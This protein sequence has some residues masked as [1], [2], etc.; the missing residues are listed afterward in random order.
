MQPVLPSRSVLFAAPARSTSRYPRLL[1]VLVMLCCGAC[2]RRSSEPDRRPAKSQS[3]TPSATAA[4]PAQ[5]PPAKPLAPPATPELPLQ[6]VACGEREFYRITQRSL[7]VFQVAEQQPPPQIRGNRIARQVAAIELTNPLNVVPFATKGALVVAETAVVRYQPGQ[8]Q[9]QRFAPIPVRGALSVL[10]DPRRAEA[11]RVRTLGEAKLEGY[12]LSSLPREPARGD[13]GPPPSLAKVTP[14]EVPLPDFDSRLFTLLADGAPLFST[15]KGLVRGVGD[16]S[17][18]ALPQLSAQPTL[19]FAD[20]SPQ[21]YWAADASGKLGLWDFKDAAA[22][23]LTSSVP[24]VVIDAAAEGD[25]VAV[26]SI[27]LTG[28]S[29]RPAVAIFA[30]GKEEARLSLGPNI[31][32]TSQPKLDLCLIAGRPWVVVGGRQW[33]QLF[34]WST[35]RLL[36]E[37]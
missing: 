12:A 16:A 13:A 8:P 20:A 24:G 9:E 23:V 34:D 33:L 25:R 31:G 36:A 37:W 22:P 1:G 7:D 17:P 35:R 18:V 4:A 19:L 2:S 21:R 3:P 29:Y 5:L 30:N 14:G 26:L 6:L 27:E 15:P 28:D 11:F 32:L 10:P